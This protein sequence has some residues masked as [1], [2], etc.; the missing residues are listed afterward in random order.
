MNGNLIE[1]AAAFGTE[2]LSTVRMRRAAACTVAKS[3]AWSREK[4]YVGSV[5]ITSFSG[6]AFVPCRLLA[7]LRQSRPVGFGRPSDDEDPGS[8]VRGADVGSADNLPRRVIPELGQVSEYGTECPH[9]LVAGV[10]HA[11]EAVEY[12]RVGV[13]FGTEESS[14]ILGYD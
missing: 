14:H 3:G 6:R 11:R 4:S 10:S 8:L 1:F 5:R 9:G 13:C 7:P 2:F 12:V